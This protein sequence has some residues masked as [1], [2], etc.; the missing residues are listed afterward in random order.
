M[1][2]RYA[3][4]PGWVPPWVDRLGVPVW[5]SDPDRKIVFINQR[6][7]ELLGRSAKKCVGKECHR[8]IRG[9]TAKGEKFCGVHCPV[10]QQVPFHKEIEPFR[11]RVG[12]GRR[13]KWVQ[14]VLII[15][16]PPDFSGPR[17]V[18]CIIDDS[19]EQRFKQYLTKVVSRT[20][21][22]RRGGRET[23][24]FRLTSREKEIL[25]RLAD[26][27]SMH[28]IAEQLDLSYTTVRNHVQHILNKLGVHS[29]VEAVA[30]YL[31]SGD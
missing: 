1:P 29:I 16:Q 9:K 13:A 2:D 20:P 28:E 15:T 26:D 19:K 12:T 7:E 23:G 17:L 30:Y 6:A 25:A 4:A 18:H 3:V 21:R 31:L 8:V 5:V 24:G 14:V 11:I 27:E 10:S 22:T